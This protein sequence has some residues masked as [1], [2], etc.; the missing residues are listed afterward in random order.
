MI[1]AYYQLWSEDNLTLYELA[2]KL[3]EMDK[4]LVGLFTFGGYKAYT[5]ILYPII[6][7][8]EFAM[9]R[10]SKRELKANSY[11]LSGWWGFPAG[12][13]QKEN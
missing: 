8:G 10:I 1:E 4:A 11:L 12:E 9:I 2:K 3:K 5:F 6:K 7:D 13:S